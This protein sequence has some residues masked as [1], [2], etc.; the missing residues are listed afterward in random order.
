VH[1]VSKSMKAIQGYYLFRPEDL[2]WRQSKLMLK[3]KFKVETGERHELLIFHV[4]LAPCRTTLRPFSE[5]S[6]GRK[7]S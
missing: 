3:S 1:D 7:D 6:A 4:S 2:F 5:L